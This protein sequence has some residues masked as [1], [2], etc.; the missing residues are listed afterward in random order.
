MSPID[1]VTLSPEIRFGL[2]CSLSIAR[3]LSKG[4]AYT[5]N[6]LDARPESIVN[7]WKPA[8]PEW[9]TC[10]FPGGSEFGV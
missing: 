8:G 3:H 9:K 1:P 6:T 5:P 4:I 2:E 7:S 10:K